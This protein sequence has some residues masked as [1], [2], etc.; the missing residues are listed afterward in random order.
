MTQQGV[1]RVRGTTDLAVS[2]KVFQW[3]VSSL[4]DTIKGKWLLPPELWSQ[5]DDEPE[6]K[7]LLREGG[8]LKVR[9]SQ[10]T[11]ITSKQSLVEDDML[12]SQ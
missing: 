12:C 2:N 10:E 7:V 4:L 1:E 3:H 11:V 9:S 5:V 8:G 6:A